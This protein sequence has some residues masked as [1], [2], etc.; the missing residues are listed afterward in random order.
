MDNANPSCPPVCLPTTAAHAMYAAR[1]APAA[2]ANS[3]PLHDTGPSPSTSN[4]T[5][6]PAQTIHSA[7][8]VRRDP[9]EA[10]ASG[11]RKSMVT[12]VPSGMRSNAA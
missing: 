11:P 1:P 4:R 5:P 8:R 9:I 12:A 6:A 10:M 2:T 7:S 3:T